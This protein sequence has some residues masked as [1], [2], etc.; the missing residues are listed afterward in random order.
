M[1]GIAERVNRTLFK[2]ARAMLWTAR[3]PVGFWTAAVQMATFL[4]NRSPTKALN[5]TPYEAYFGGKPN[6]GFIRIF[7]CK[8]K[9]A[10][11]DSLRIKS[12][13]YAKSPDCILIGYFETENLYELWDLHKGSII[14]ARDV[15]FWENEL[16]SDLLSKWALP[17][18]ISILPITSEYLL[19]HPLPPEP[20]I[21]PPLIPLPPVA[22][23]RTVPSLTK[24]APSQP[25]TTFI[26]MTQETVDAVNN[27]HQK[28]TNLSLPNLDL[29]SLHFVQAQ[30]TIP[31]DRTSLPNKDDTTLTTSAISVD[32][33]I[34]PTDDI[35][36][37]ATFT[38]PTSDDWSDKYIADRMGISTDFCAELVYNAIWQKD[39]EQTSAHYVLAVSH[40]E[41]DAP[42]IPKQYIPKSYH[43]AIKSPR[44]E[45]WQQAM[46]TQFQKL[47][48]A[49][50]WTPT[51]LPLGKR[52]IPCKWVFSLKGGAKAES[53]QQ[54]E[55][56]RLV[57][58]GDMQTA[59]EDYGETFAPVIKLV[60][61]RML[62]TLAAINDMDPHH[63][64]VVAAF[65][66]GELEEEVYIKVPPGFES[67][68]PEQSVDRKSVV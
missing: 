49:N 5:T 53:I 35:T 15:I 9:V 56:V 40:M 26:D 58:R 45:Y 13:W 25:G 22:Q 50:T 37:D 61:L 14:R 36:T 16:G 2:H 41:I 24:Q 66:N 39:L 28:K 27:P 57:A 62:L 12:N 52:A 17:D 3:L 11:P 8:A 6:L 19:Q 23:P 59:G 7:G 30:S 4:K 63:W 67:T 21:T 65:L 46:Q 51:S 44:A 31:D 48:D 32:R 60:S 33:T 55:T 34:L 43:A 10:I 38:H 64:D 1:N 68:F 47:I 42:S 18:G 54:T 20:V 29:P